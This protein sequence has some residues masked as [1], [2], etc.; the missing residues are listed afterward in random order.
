MKL[1][2]RYIN[3]ESGKKEEAHI[4]NTVEEIEFWD[5]QR[6]GEVSVISVARA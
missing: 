6:A 5:R 2:V 1:N 3:L 4:D